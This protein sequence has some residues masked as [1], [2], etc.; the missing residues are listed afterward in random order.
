[1]IYLAAFLSIIAIILLLRMFRER[2]RCTLF[3]D[4]KFERP[5]CQA[6]IG[7]VENANDFE[8]SIYVLKVTDLHSLKEITD[9]RPISDERLVSA[10]DSLAWLGDCSI[11][12][13]DR[14]LPIITFDTDLCKNNL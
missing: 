4:L 7:L 8:P 1:M 6:T 3:L 11:P 5:Y 12:N 9:E 2:P 14:I 10:L 13:W